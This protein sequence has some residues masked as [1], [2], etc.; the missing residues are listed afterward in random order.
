M[1]VTFAKQQ[2][3]ISLDKGGLHASCLEYHQQVNQGSAALHT[4]TSH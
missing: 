1:K 2:L 4:T 3:G